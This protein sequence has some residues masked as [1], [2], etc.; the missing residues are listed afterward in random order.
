MIF[1]GGI[2]AGELRSKLEC[3]A[4]A[5]GLSTATALIGIAPK[6]MATTTTPA[7]QIRRTR[8]DAWR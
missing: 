6:T 1:A 3:A 8:L 5:G 4:E 7:L 2:G